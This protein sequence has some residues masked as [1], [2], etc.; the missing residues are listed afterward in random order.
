M[1][2]LGQADTLGR[3]SARVH[4]VDLVKF[5]LFVE[6]DTISPSAA[7]R[8]AADALRR[9]QAA[10]EPDVTAITDESALRREASRA[11]RR[12]SSKA[13]LPRTVRVGAGER[14]AASTYLLS[15]LSSVPLQPDER[16][17]G[18]FALERI[19]GLRSGRGGADR[20]LADRL[21][22]QE[23]VADAGHLLSYV[24]RSRAVHA[25]VARNIVELLCVWFP[26]LLPAMY[27]TS[28]PSEGPFL[29]I[30]SEWT[31]R[32]TPEI[33]VVLFASLLRTTSELADAEAAALLPALDPLAATL[34][35][36]DATR[37]AE[38][39]A[40]ATRLRPLQRTRLEWVQPDARRDTA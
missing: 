19:L 5:A 26:A 6:V 3:H 21:P 12:R 35:L 22:S 34:E 20:D 30:V 33:Y 38:L 32:L 14:E 24:R 23:F 36:V 37:G 1:A 25:R 27:A 17:A 18:R 29:E 4:G 39:R 16:A 7:L 9:M 11:A 10:L 40:V 15:A 2:T 13:A 8:I 28:P 31:Q